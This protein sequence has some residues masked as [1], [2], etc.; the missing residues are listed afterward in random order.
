MRGAHHLETFL[1]MMSVERGA[2]ANTLAAYRRDLEDFGAFLAARNKP[3]NEADQTDISAYLAGL[4]AQELATTTQAR[5]LSALRRFHRFLYGEGVRPDDPTGLAEAPKKRR[6][7]PKVIS[8]EEI[9]ALLS[10]AAREAC[11]DDLSPVK[12]MAAARL[13]ALIEIA[14]ATGL[15]VSEL[16]GLPAS[17]ARPDLRVMTVRGKG[18]KERIVPLSDRARRAIATYV[19][20]RDGLERGGGKFLFPADSESGH[21]TRQSFGRDLKWV[22][23]AAGLPPEKVSPHVLRHAF[24]SH[25]LAGGADLR[26]VQALLGHADIATTEIYTHVLDTR[27]TELVQEHHPLARDDGPPATAK[28]HEPH[29]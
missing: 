27:L 16:V 6:A 20:L 8:A 1:E 2:A 24:A 12:R 13:V 10:V 9:I 5:R 7:L 23:V 21:L 18:N 22:A 14:Y 26:I 17:A 15:R 11:R 25:L 19:A 3:L 28:R 29:G 4:K